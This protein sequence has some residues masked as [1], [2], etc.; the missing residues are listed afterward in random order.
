M[1]ASTLF[2]ILA[3]WRLDDILG[4]DISTQSLTDTRG[5][6]GDRASSRM[7]FSSHE[8]PRMENHAWFRIAQRAL[9]PSFAKRAS[10]L[11][12]LA[13]KVR[14]RDLSPARRAGRAFALVK[15]LATCASGY[16]FAA[17][18]RSHRRG[19]GQGRDRMGPATARLDERADPPREDGNVRSR[20]AD[21]SSLER[22]ILNAISFR[23]EKRRRGSY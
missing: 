2:R 19:R 13:A 5:S 4:R 10:R 23:A 12:I 16:R 3:S 15:F 14:S 11:A 22:S 7:T 21:S 17:V 9:R 1:P 8:N 20:A 18:C 6:F